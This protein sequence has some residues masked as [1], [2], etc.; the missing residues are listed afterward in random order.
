MNLSMND[1]RHG[2]RQADQAP[3]HGVWGLG[4]AVHRHGGPHR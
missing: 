1:H 2:R 4:P 3:T